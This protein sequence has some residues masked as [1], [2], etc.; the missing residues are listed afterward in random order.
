MSRPCALALTFLVVA[1]CASVQRHIL[2]SPAA[3]GAPWHELTSEHFVVRTD[4]PDW[5]AGEVLNGFDRSARALIALALPPGTSPP[6][7]RL[8]VV[9]FAHVEDYRALLDDGSIGECR[10]RSDGSRPLLIVASG[11]NFLRVVEQTMRTVQHELTHWLMHRAVPAAPL[12]LDEGNAQYW[13][14]LRL[15]DGQAIVGSLPPLLLLADWLPAADVL[16]A[17][18]DSFYGPKHARYYSTAWGIVYLLR[19]KHAD[20]FAHYLTA[21]AAGTRGEAAW[22]G[23]FGSFGAREL[24]A[25]MH[26]WFSADRPWAHSVPMV[27]AIR[28]PQSVTAI[29]PVQVHLLW[30]DLRPHD[31]K[32]FDAIAADL[33][34]AQQ[35][36]PDSAT[37]A[38]ALAELDLQ[39]ERY[40]AAL[41]RVDS[42]LTEHPDDEQL[43]RLRGEALV[44]QQLTRPEADR[45]F[46]VAIALAD[47]LGHD[48]ASVP[49]LRFAS[50]VLARF[51]DR[52]RGLA[53][54][55]RAAARAPDCAGC[56]ETLAAARERTHDLPGAIAALEQALRLLPDGV[57]E[58]RMTG[59]LAQLRKKLAGN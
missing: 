18:R 33:K 22:R 2:Q 53:L 4:Y 23:A 55:E 40:T 24:D 25:E 30:A 16:A 3:G 28:D 36:A 47:R 8:D 12:W 51:G 21:L 26:E 42:A 9:A 48:Q 54:A 59:W 17:D 1:G 52:A 38:A 34:T 39:R 32:H 14:T 50:H 7:D 43:L 58:E 13:Q 46:G 44:E 6:R 20:A 57:T 56:F 45:D 19:T 49:S 5:A 10:F 31:T 27:L 29:A 41:T 11:D 35:L 15:E 37:V